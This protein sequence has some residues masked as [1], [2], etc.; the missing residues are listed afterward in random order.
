MP[1][2]TSSTGTVQN[3][4]SS[5]TM[6][7]AGETLVSVQN[8]GTHWNQAQLQQSN[9]SPCADNTET[10]ILFD[11]TKILHD[12]DDEQHNTVIKFKLEQ[13]KVV[14]CRDS[15]IST[16]IKVLPFH[17]LSYADLKPFCC[18]FERKGCL[19]KS[20]KVIRPKGL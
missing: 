9:D 16:P 3:K 19:L 2:A 15:T 11:S 18:K 14:Q 13:N 4:H 10:N 1:T 20:S 12:T 5:P 7:D 6:V 17:V 8:P